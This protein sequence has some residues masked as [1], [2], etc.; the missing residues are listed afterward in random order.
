MTSCSSPIVNPK[1]LPCGESKQRFRR[2]R[3]WSSG[4]ASENVMNDLTAP[5]SPANGHSSHA[6]LPLD[7][8]TFEAIGNGP[9]VEPESLSA[10]DVL[11][12]LRRYRGLLLVWAI[13]GAMLALLIG[14]VQ[15]PIYRAQATIEIQGFNGNLLSGRDTNQ[16]MHESIPEPFIQTQLKILHSETLLQR[17]VNKLKLAERSEFRPA[18]KRWLRSR[19]AG[20]DLTPSPSERVRKKLARDISAR[21]S[22]QASVIEILYESP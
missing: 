16:P 11:D 12:A 15:T 10:R 4:A 19:L 20:G 7:W 5:N 3:V 13:S 2:Q 8:S 21:T 14:W 6:N 17:V 18:P 9:K 1:P 22:G